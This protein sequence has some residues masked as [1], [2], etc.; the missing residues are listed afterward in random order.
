MCRPM[1]S[2]GTEIQWCHYPD[3]VR[4]LV[5]QLHSSFPL[6][7]LNRLYNVHAMVELKSS[8]CLV[9]VAHISRLRLQFCRWLILSCSIKRWLCPALSISRESM[10]SRICM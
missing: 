8:T 5:Y 4:S 2:V 10:A 3:C 1:C 9:L 7:V 6:N